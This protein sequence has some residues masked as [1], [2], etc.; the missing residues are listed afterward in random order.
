MVLY[1]R[2]MWE[3]ATLS[4][5]VQKVGGS[6]YPVPIPR[7]FLGGPLS[8][9]QKNLHSSHQF[10]VYIWT[11]WDLEFFWANCR[12]ASFLQLWSHLARSNVR[13]AYLIF[14][15]RIIGENVCRLDEAFSSNLPKISP[16]GVQSCHIYNSKPEV[17][18]E[19]ISTAFFTTYIGLK[20]AVYNVRQLAP[21]VGKTAKVPRPQKI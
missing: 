2:K 8:L 6:W 7:N 12:H 4:T 17:E 3:F 5:P 16:L 14:S 21:Q 19:K 10:R 18:M 15:V 13:K 20:G 1:S 9:Q 11:T